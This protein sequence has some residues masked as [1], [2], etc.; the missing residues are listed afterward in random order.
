[1]YEVLYSSKTELLLCS[2]ASLSPCLGGV[3][4]TAFP[5]TANTYNLC[6]KT[7]EAVVY[8]QG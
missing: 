4:F 6:L 1:M 2:M 8:I 5:V 3:L 7:F